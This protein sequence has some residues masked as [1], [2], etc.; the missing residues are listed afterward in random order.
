MALTIFDSEL[1]VMDVIWNNPEGITAKEISLILTEKAGWNKNTTYTVISKLIEKSFIERREPN[2]ICVALVK[3]EEVQKGE[4][5][6]LVERLFNGSRA[7][8]FSAMLDKEEL[9]D[10]EL[11]EIK[12][13]LKKF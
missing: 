12:E 10:K 9:S 6:N 5:E 1:K 13:L 7:A 2:F 4:T 3:K 8:F 11:D